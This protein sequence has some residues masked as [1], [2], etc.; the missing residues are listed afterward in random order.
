MLKLFLQIII[1]KV[2]GKLAKLILQTLIIIM[3]KYCRH[4]AGKRTQKLLSENSHRVYNASARWLCIS[5]TNS[6][7]PGHFLVPACVDGTIVKTQES[8]RVEQHL[9]LNLQLL[10]SKLAQ[11]ALH[12]PPEVALQCVAGHCITN[13]WS[14]FFFSFSS[15]PSFAFDPLRGISQG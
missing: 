5:V 9:I 14:S 3:S 1:I 11:A 13:F 10:R 2:I 4:A 6:F 8:T 7:G 15:L 12:A